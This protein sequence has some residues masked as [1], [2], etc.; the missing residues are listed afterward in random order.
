MTLNDLNIL[1]TLLFDIDNLNFP[2]WQ[3]GKRQKFLDSN[4]LNKVSDIFS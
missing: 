1:K 2:S 3:K 4:G